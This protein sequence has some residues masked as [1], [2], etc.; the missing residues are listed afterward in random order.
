[1]LQ[2]AAARPKVFYRGYDVFDQA[3][4]GFRSDVP[5]ENGRKFFRYDTAVAGNGNGGHDYGTRLSDQD[6]QAVVEYMKR[7]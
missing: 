3:K 5:D 1:L 6:K 2:P 7:L 4:V